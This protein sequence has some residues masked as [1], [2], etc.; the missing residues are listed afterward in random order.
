MNVVLPDC[1]ADNNEPEN[2]GST[3][4]S[5]ESDK[6]IVIVNEV[7]EYEEEEYLEEPCNEREAVEESVPLFTEYVG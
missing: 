2:N 4:S 7:L 5:E 1:T 6:D 3:S